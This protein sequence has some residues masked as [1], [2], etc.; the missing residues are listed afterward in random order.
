MEISW[1]DLS[2][3]LLIYLLPL[4]TC[5]STYCALC[6]IQDYGYIRFSTSTAPIPV[7]CEEQCLFLFNRGQHRTIRAPSLF[8]INQHDKTLAY[9]DYFRKVSSFK[10]QVKLVS[11]GCH[12]AI[13][14][15]KSC[16]RRSVCFCSEGCGGASICPLT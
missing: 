3:S 6:H 16:A 8:E 14:C 9:Q 5:T 11:L 1:S 2:T 4:L 7:L 10:A 15:A 12:K 13:Q